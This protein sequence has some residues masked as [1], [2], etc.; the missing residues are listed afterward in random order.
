VFI[1]NISW[2]SSWR[3]AP[4]WLTA[5]A[6][7]IAAANGYLARREA[8]KSVVIARDTH[9]LVNS[10]AGQALLQRVELLQ[11]LAVQAHRFAALTHDPGDAAAALAFEVQVKA[12]ETSYQDHMRKQA[13]VDARVEKN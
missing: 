1:P 6:A 11:A 2:V 9:T 10:Q 3:S 8:K 7:I 4:S 12:A 5:A 13:V